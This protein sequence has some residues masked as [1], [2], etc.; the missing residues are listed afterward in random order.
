MDGP[1]ELWVRHVDGW[2]QFATAE[3]GVEWRVDP[4]EFYAEL[5]R[6]TREALAASARLSVMVPEIR[7]LEKGVADLERLVH[8][9]NRPR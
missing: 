1:F 4:G 8:T 6:G 7:G 3:R 9:L 5:I 2:L